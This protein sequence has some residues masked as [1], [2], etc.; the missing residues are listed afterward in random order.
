[1][2]NTDEEFGAGTMEIFDDGRD[3]SAWLVWSM[4]SRRRISEGVFSRPP[5]KL[6]V[7][8]VSRKPKKK[9]RRKKR[10]TTKG[11]SE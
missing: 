9:T 6:Q 7:V 11:V 8:P 4:N 5:E 2:D 3:W 10:R 1:M